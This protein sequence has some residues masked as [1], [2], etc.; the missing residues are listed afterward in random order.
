MCR[1]GSE[2]QGH[3]FLHCDFERAGWNRLFYLFDPSKMSMIKIEKA[4]WCCFIKSSLYQISS[5]CK[6][7]EFSVFSLL[8]IFQSVVESQ[9][10]GVFCSNFLFFSVFEEGMFAIVR[11]FRSIGQYMLFIA[12]LLSFCE[13]IYSFSDPYVKDFY[14]AIWMDH[15]PKKIKISSWELSLGAINIIDRLQIQCRI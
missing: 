9:V 11:N 1:R 3:I 6:F 5:L 4:S 12:F 8:D 2:N 13:N 10:S 15:L 14:S 7:E